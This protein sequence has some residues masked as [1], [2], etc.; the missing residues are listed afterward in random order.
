MQ[1]WRPREEIIDKY[2]ASASMSKEAV[3]ML[4]LQAAR[5]ARP[6]GAPVDKYI[7]LARRHHGIEV[8]VI[9]LGG[10]LSAMSRSETGFAVGG[11]DSFTLW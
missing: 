4:W 2:A 3:R 7:E 8:E 6:V 11:R 10:G 5:Q 9:D 1:K